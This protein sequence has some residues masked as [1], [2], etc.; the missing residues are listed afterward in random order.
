MKTFKIMFNL[1]VF[2]YIGVD[3][4]INIL[5]SIVQVETHGVCGREG[6]CSFP[7]QFSSKN[8][9]FISF[10]NHILFNPSRI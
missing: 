8:K 4:L 6:G 9:L 2:L 7:Y 5:L 1:Q 3:Y 10:K